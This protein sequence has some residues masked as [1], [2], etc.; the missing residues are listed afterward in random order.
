MFVQIGT[1]QQFVRWL[2]QRMQCERARP[3]ATV[4]LRY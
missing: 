4:I 3:H 1:G 2:F